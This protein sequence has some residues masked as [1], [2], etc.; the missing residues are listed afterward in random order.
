MHLSIM[1]TSL[2]FLVTGI[3]EHIACDTFLWLGAS[4]LSSCSSC[5]RSCRCFP[6]HNCTP[7]ASKQDGYLFLFAEI[8]PDCKMHLRSGL[9]S[10]AAYATLFAVSKSKD[11]GGGSQLRQWSSL[12][13]IVTAIIGNILISF[14]LNIQRYAHIRLERESHARRPQLSKQSKGSPKST[15]NYGTTAQEDI[16]EERARLNAEAPG[17]GGR[18]NGKHTQSGSD[19]DEER[20]PLKTSFDSDDTLAEEKEDNDEEDRKS[21]LRSPYWWLGITLMTVGEAGNF[22]AYGFAPASIVSPLGVVALISNCVIAPFMLKERFRPRDAWGVVV[23]IAGAVTVVLSAKQSETKMGPDDLWDAIRRWEFLTY[24]GITALFIIALMVASPKYGSRT[25]LIDLGLVGL[26]G[27][28]T[29]LA[30][31]GVASL[32]SDTLWRALTFPITYVLVLV[33]VLSAIMQIKYVNK[34]L[35]SF[36]S[37]QV[38]PTQFVM[39]TL[40][41][42][43]G[44]AVLYREFETTTVERVAKFVG[45][46]FLTFFGVYLITSGRPKRRDDMDEDDDSDEEEAIRLID[47]EAQYSL[48]KQSTADTLR[49][50][51]STN[52]P[53]TPTLIGT[54]TP[55]RLSIDSIPSIAVTPTP[56]TRSQPSL[57]SGLNQNPW[58]TSPTQ[59]STPK[60]GPLNRAQSEVPPSTSTTPFYTPLT[61]HAPPLNRNAS[62]AA[63]ET[64]TKSKRSASPP[65]ADRPLPT[66]HSTLSRSAR[67]SISRLL[68][69]PFLAPL[70]SSLSAVVA[71]SLRKGEGSPGFL[72]RARSS[73]QREARR[74]SQGQIGD[75]GDM[76]FLSQQQTREDGLGVVEEGEAGKNQNPKG[77]MRS[78]S[79]TLGRMMGSKGKERDR[80]GGDEGEG[81][82]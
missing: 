54:T 32:L 57:P 11:G 42:I 55:R 17:P 16:A 14:A 20:R 66:P 75:V 58:I 43:I 64:P 72:R 8:R 44:S 49:P 15:R 6:I 63:P 69:G 77:R 74:Q 52:R 19:E 13:G 62:I 68:P 7:S 45:G 40:S 37:T 25:V 3:E 78:M 67:G 81:P 46:C 1:P 5:T 9:Q 71:D 26:F 79:E 18:P 31:K 39:F 53:V 82:R 51:I 47:D 4:A 50:S 70:S 76:G 2:D 41:V 22:L 24:I 33:L 60:P 59:P 48:K 12:I 36:D 65:K 21:Y 10:G 29:A 23:A 35:Q 80:G 38:I 73:R 61:H 34:A 28:Y 27:G 56:E 30:T